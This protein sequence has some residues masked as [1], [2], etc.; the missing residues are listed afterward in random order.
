ME[1][2]RRLIYCL[3]Y[4]ERFAL[5]LGQVPQAASKK[6]HFPRIKNRWVNDLTDLAATA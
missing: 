1:M 6:S 2:D 4:L 3:Y 5:V